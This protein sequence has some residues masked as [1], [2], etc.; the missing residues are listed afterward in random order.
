M[1]CRNADRDLLHVAWCEQPGL[2]KENQLLDRFFQIGVRLAHINLHDLLAG[3]L[4]HVLDKDVQRQIFSVPAHVSGLQHEETVA[5][6]EAK[7]VGELFPEGREI[8]IAHVDVFLVDRVHIFRAFGCEAGLVRAVIEVSGGGD[9]KVVPG[10]AVRQLA[11]GIFR[12][13]QHIQ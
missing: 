11:A 9:V 6:T 5:Q 12:A 3:K 1:L 8:P 13:R 7:G 2:F 4:A 10:P